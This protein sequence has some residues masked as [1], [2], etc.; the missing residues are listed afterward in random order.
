[1]K[2]NLKHFMQKYEADPNFIK[3]Y[4]SA[5]DIWVASRRERNGVATLYT[6]NI[7]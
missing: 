1:M 4:V 6:L 7:A 3:N 5:R 2:V